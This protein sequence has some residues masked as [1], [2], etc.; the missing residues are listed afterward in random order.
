MKQLCLL[1]PASTIKLHSSLTK[2]K[3]KKH[4][5]DLVQALQKLGAPAK[6]LHAKLYE[7]ITSFS[8]GGISSLDLPSL[9]NPPGYLHKE[10]KK[11]IQ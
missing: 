6:F 4:A 5:T 1:S 10:R 7:K 8:S 2:K 9:R 11:K 3:K